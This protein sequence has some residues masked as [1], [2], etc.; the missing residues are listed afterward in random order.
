MR[1]DFLEGPWEL[2]LY[3]ILASQGAPD[4]ARP[5]DA[6]SAPG[7]GTLTGRIMRGWAPTPSNDT[8]NM[9]LSYYNV[10]RF[11]ARFVRYYIIKLRSY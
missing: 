9:I 10:L 1:G 2:I 7:R 8:I 11:D 3:E 6:T 5:R 4:P